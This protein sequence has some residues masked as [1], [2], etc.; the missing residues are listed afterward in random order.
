MTYERRAGK[1]LL[2]IAAVFNLCGPLWAAAPGELRLL[3]GRTQSP[4]LIDA[5]VR[6][7]RLHRDRQS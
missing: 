2:A 5:I 3:D 7:R 4:E 6:A 1:A